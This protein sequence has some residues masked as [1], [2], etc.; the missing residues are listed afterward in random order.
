[1]LVLMRS[2]AVIAGI[3]ALI[4][5]SLYASLVVWERTHPPRLPTVSSAAAQPAV[6]YEGS[7]GGAPARHGR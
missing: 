5:V 6:L 7:A 4:A 3:F 2:C 1:M